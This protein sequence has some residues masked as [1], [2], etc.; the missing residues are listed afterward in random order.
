[1]TKFIFVEIWV[2]LMSI[3]ERKI[4]SKT[5]TYRPML[6]FI[7]GEIGVKRSQGVAFEQVSCPYSEWDADGGK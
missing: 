5:S 1:M 2:G 4:K 7:V 6:L 3:R